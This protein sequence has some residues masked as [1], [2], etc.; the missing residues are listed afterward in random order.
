MAKRFLLYSLLLLAILLTYPQECYALGV[1]PLVI[2]LD[3][4]PGDRATFELELTPGEQGRTVKL[5][6]FEPRQLLTGGLEYRQATPQEYYPIGWL[7]LPEE[8]TVP[9]GENVTV[10]CQVRV[11]YD[12]FGSNTVIIMVEPGVEDAETGI[13]FRVRYAV[14][15]N[16]NVPRPGLRAQIDIEDFFLESDEEGRPQVVAHVKN[17][18]PLHY[19]TT[20]E[21]TIRDE[22][23]RLVERVA[24]NS[25]AGWQA[26]RGTSR[27]YAGAEVL[28]L[29]EVTEYLA[30][31]EYDLRLF[32]N[33]A[34]GR[35]SISS[36][37]VSV[38]E[39]QFVQP[40]QYL[41]FSPQ[42]VEDSLRPGASLTQ[43]L[44]LENRSGDPVFVE[45]RTQ[46][47][48]QEYPHC[49]FDSFGIEFRGGRDFELAPNRSTRTVLISRSPR[50]IEVGGYYGYLNIDV[51]SKE[52]ELLETH[53]I[54][55]S[56]TVGEVEEYEGAIRSVEYDYFT[57]E[58]LFSV[59]LLNK[60]KVHMVPTGVLYLI[61]EDGDVVRSMRLDMQEGQL[62]ILPQKGAILTGTARDLEPGDYTARIVINYENQEVTS[63][64][65]P[66]NIKP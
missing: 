11:P 31:G 63:A 39:G 49:V 46:K 62:N 42:V 27:I 45:I 56:I 3:L 44:Q 6:L 51:F 21:V 30:P 14:R 13:V 28:L 65:I 55:F 38:E 57:E 43:A 64:E 41:R 47:I 16:I 36:S 10:E 17:P 12:A 9:P 29:G 24:M 19:N 58:Y 5:G 32:I 48:E 18:S 7:D 37:R 53:Q 25:Q 20:A 61:D 22:N 54:P 33:F 34:D 52:R 23:R 40:R 59:Y 26:G 15:V 1:R 60:S 50:N 35:Q 2:D 8:V 66:L 4:E